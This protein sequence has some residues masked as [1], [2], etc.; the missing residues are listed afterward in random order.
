MRAF[1]HEHRAY[2]WLAASLVIAVV[3]I[4]HNAGVDSREDNI[5]GCNSGNANRQS[6]YD[7]AVGD[8]ADALYFS[9]QEHDREIA[10]GWKR[11]YERKTEEA[12]RIVAAAEATGAQSAP[13]QVTVICEVRYPAPSWWPL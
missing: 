6:D 13:G 7:A 9:T 2:L 11:R 1:W 4:Q 12:G 8:A 10:A 3:A 5:N